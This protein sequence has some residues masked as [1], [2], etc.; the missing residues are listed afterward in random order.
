MASLQYPNESPQ[1]R[2]AREALLNEELALREQ[3][4]R[5]AKQRRTLPPGGLL[6]ENYV[7]EERVDGKT[8][9]TLFSDLFA[10]KKDTLFLYSFMYAPDMAAACP[11]CTS[12]LDGLHGQLVHLE[13]R[14]N[15]A[16]VA[17]H[18]LKKIHEF[19]ASRGW[20]G[21]RLLSSANNTYNSDYFGETDTGQTTMANVFVRSNDE[22]RLFWGTEMSFANAIEG[23]NMRHLDQAWAMWNILDMTPGGR[24]E[25]FYPALSYTSD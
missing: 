12:F 17:K 18:S 25:Q 13:P 15:V 11:M 20:D 14:I 1:Y 21:F 16:V 5:V 23:G 24:G 2:T 19:A 6:K 3:I 9:R 7:F 22:I 8:R 4:E 10:P